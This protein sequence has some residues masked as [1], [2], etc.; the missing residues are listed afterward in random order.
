MH[1]MIFIT[2]LFIYSLQMHAGETVHIA[3]I[4]LEPFLTDEGKGKTPGGIAVD[5]W[6]DYIAPQMD[7]NV[8]FSGPYPI[9]RAEYMLKNGE[10]D[11]VMQLTK[12]PSREKEFLFPETH[13]TGIKSCLVVTKDSKTINV[14][15]TEDMYGW[16]ILFIDSAY[17]PEMLLHKR[18]NIEKV[19]GTDFRQVQLKMLFAGRG[20]AMLDINQVSLLFYL[21]NRG[22]LDRVRIISLPV[23]PQNVYTIFSKTAKG[24]NIK[25]RFDQVNRKGLK[26]RIFEKMT[27]DYIKRSG[28]ENFNAE[29]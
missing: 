26:E 8:E 1:R 3:V 19:S 15:K 21:R 29:K 20:E 6:R 25:E 9:R 13:L 18:I 16:T 28:L 24:M 4:N 7:V 11:A 10:V 2:L 27:Q 17:V 5:Y 12:I 23:K 22:Y 14:S